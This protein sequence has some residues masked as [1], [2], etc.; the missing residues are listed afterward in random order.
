MPDRSAVSFG[1]NDVEILARIPSYTGWLK[2]EKLHLKCR[3]FEGG[4]SQ[5]FTRELL[6]RGH[7]VGVLLYDPHLDKVL[8]VEQFRVGCLDD[9]RNGPWALELVAGLLEAGEIPEEVARREAVEEAGVSVGRLLQICEYY[10]SPGASNEKLTVFC[11]GFDASLPGGIFGVDDE[12]EN[13]RTTILGRSE[14]LAAVASGRINNAMSI[15]A[16]QWLELNLADVRKT[17]TASSHDM[18]G[19]QLSTGKAAPQRRLRPPQQGFD[20]RC[21]T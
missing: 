9:V 12:F 19:Q 14:A 20:H 3:L 17:L 10:N 15:I 8:M 11:A 7:G 16:L 1:L 5:E 4:W 6:L 2:I 18:P 13:I 21:K